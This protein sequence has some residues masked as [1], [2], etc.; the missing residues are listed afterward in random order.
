MAS[1]ATTKASPAVPTQGPRFSSGESE[2]A[3]ALV[4]QGRPP[5]GAWLRS[6]STAVHRAA[7]TTAVEGRRPRRTMTV[8]AVRPNSTAASDSKTPS[9]IHGMSP[10]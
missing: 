3:Y 1:S 9:A 10:A 4:P 8:R 7:T 6:S 5:H 2:S